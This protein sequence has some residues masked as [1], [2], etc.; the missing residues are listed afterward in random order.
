MRDGGHAAF[1]LMEAWRE[2][3]TNQKAK[4]KSQKAKSKKQ[5]A[6]SKKQKAKSKDPSMVSPK[7]WETG[8]PQSK[9]QNLKSKI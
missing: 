7:M 4:V 1:I 8:V 6:K 2:Q 5:K 3:K 9:I